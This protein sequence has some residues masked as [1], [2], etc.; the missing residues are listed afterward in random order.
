MVIWFGRLNGW[1]SQVYSC[2]CLPGGMR[3]CQHEGS[4]KRREIKEGAWTT[5][6]GKRHK[7]HQTSRG[8]NI[9]LN[10]RRQGKRSADKQT[11]LG[12]D[13]K[14]TA[15]P[16][17]WPLTSPVTLTGSEALCWQETLQQPPCMWQSVI[18]LS[19]YC[20]QGAWQALGRE[21]PSGARAILDATCSQNDF[22]QS[23]TVF[24]TNDKIVHQALQNTL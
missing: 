10:G 9:T 24:V 5:G 22:I 3:A 19:N 12:V 2:V 1:Y 15:D 17:P 4:N 8:N 13:A 7:P 23:V 21:R 16:S 14:Q 6:R 18:S 11:K 20:A